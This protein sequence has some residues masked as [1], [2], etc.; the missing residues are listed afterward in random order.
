M[1]SLKLAL[2]T[3]QQADHVHRAL[4]DLARGLTDAFASPIPGDAEDQ[5]KSHLRPFVEAAATALG[6]RD[7]VVKTESRVAAVR[8]RPDFGVGRVSG[9]TGH[10]ELKAPGR[11][12][13]PNR[14]TGRDGRQWDKFKS[15]PNLIYTDGHEWT[16][17]HSGKRIDGARLSGD[18]T[19]DGPSTVALSDARQ[20]GDLLQ[21]F[22]S[23]QPIAPATPKRL[24]ET[25]AP[26]ARLLRRDVLEALRDSNSAISQLRRDWRSVLFANAD[27][28]QFADAY[29]QTLTYALLLARLGGLDTAGANIAQDTLRERGHTLLA[30]VLRTLAHPQAQ[31]E[32]ET[33]VKLLERVIGAVDV[34]RL[35]RGGADPWLYFYEDFLAEYDPKLRNDR[36]VYYT[37][38]QVVRAQVRL[39]GELLRRRF[40]KELTYADDG[41][42]TLD[43]AA[44]TGSYP[45]AVIEHALTAVADRMGNGAVPG[46]A[47]AMARN[48]HAFELLV[49][50]YSV[51]HLHVSERIEAHGGALPNDGAHVYLTDTLESPHAATP[52]LM[53]LSL[54]TL[55][56]EH[57]RARRIKA[58]T[59]I[60]VCL[61]NPPYDRQQ[62]DLGDE[63]TQQK[64]GWVRFRLADAEEA[65]RP[66]LDDFLDPARH[67]GASVHLKNLYNDYVYF[68]RWA[69]W[70]V[71]DSTQGP[72]IVSFITA[73]SYLRGPGFVGM[74]E[75]MRRT[76]DELWILDL[77]G[78]SLGARKTE[79]VFAIRTPVA[80]AVGIR[81]GIPKPDQPA[82]VRYARLSGSADQKLARLDRVHGFDDLEWQPCFDGW[83][84]PLLPQ[85]SGNYFAWPTLSNL[86][87]WQ[88]SGVQAK[89]TWPIAPDSETLQRRWNAILVSS[90][91]PHAFRETRDRRIDKTY[92]DFRT[93]KSLKALADL[94]SDSPCPP[95]EPYAYRSF[96]RQWLIADSR[97]ADFIR[98]VLWYAQSDRQVYLTSLLTG[99]L[100]PGPAATVSAH[101]PDLHHF[102]GSYGGKDVI[103]F[104]RDADVTEPNVT[105]G[106]LETLDQA[107]GRT[108][109]AAEI[110]AYAYALLA[111]P[112]YVDRFSE[113]LTVPGPRLPLTKD[114]ELFQRAAT[115]G[116]ELIWRHTYCQRFT[117]PGRGYGTVPQGTARC[118]NPVGESLDDYPRG[119]EYHATTQTLM[120]GPGRFEPVHP[121]VW[122][123]SVS[124]FRVVRSWLRYRMRQGA[125]HQSSP[126]DAIRPTL[127]TAQFTDELLELLW[128]LE[129]TLDHYPALADLL[130]AI[131]A[132][133][134][135]T[136]DELP[137]PS[138]Q[139]RQAPKIDRESSRG[140]EY[141]QSG[142]E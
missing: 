7:V 107:L 120:V 53:P 94:D 28:N 95:V 141:A 133:P 87:P 72:G 79:N 44:G 14:Y 68:W 23:W 84:Q 77:E 36:G 49:G 69:L 89:R 27:S 4:Q 5:L 137:Q 42:V 85:G 50:P 122:E 74:R 24:A 106:L 126:L 118:E 30:D 2:V 16:L 92:A 21:T 56:D 19:T 31:D 6:S 97:T 15:L 116:A 125:G 138:N 139:Q 45:L 80:I 1:A 123:F 3:D 130:D 128:T 131:T 22:F 62:I 70:K 66:L 98:P 88:Q 58:E 90:D 26:L 82:V 41:V 55:G 47:S 129:A 124:G 71:F 127:W 63:E 67:A 103:P 111:S 61:G 96:D 112:A 17:F 39:V 51:A 132:G 59:P 108:V 114:P 76:F 34:D 18:L 32:T 25:L 38:V 135:F 57:E 54:R 117:G 115:L 110:F 93:R 102:R 75:V 99:V 109:P 119:F 78:D 60:L 9:L 100:G 105:A 121:R 142:M 13:N 35:R 40:G 12:A 29:A 48:V 8:G 136:A 83:Q 46:H 52:G 33:S 91:Q 86:F 65:A 64:G 81:R 134:T 104:W 11:G 43:P 113:E 101:V 37:P 73:A 20:L 140:S 10:I